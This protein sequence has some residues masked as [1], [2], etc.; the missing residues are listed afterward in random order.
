[1]S[2][3][4]TVTAQYSYQAWQKA[5]RVLRSN[6]SVVSFRETPSDVTMTFAAIDAPCWPVALK[7]HTE[8]AQNSRSLAIRAM[9]RGDAQEA[10]MFAALSQHSRTRASDAQTGHVSNP[11]TLL[12]RG[13]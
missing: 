11:R 9:M 6:V 7:H 1:M 13:L 10:L 12:R 5:H 8:H 3:T 2:K 4:L